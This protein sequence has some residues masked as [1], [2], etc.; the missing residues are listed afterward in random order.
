M[1]A[2]EVSSLHLCRAPWAPDLEFCGHCIVIGSVSSRRRHRVG[3][4]EVRPQRDHP[5]LPDA[6]LSTRAGTHSHPSRPGG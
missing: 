1:G 2:A 3:G 5:L 6:S 4:W